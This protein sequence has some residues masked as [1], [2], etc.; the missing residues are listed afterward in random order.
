MDDSMED[1]RAAFAA[2]PQV[3]PADAEPRVREI[4]DDI[5]TVLRVPFVN[6]L[7]RVMANDAEYL[8]RSWRYLR[9]IANSRSFEA[10][11]SKLRMTT[12]SR[13]HIRA[14][15]SDWS[16]LGDLDRA[17]AFT[18]SIDYVLPKLM[19]IAMALDGVPAAE[20]WDGGGEIPAGVAQGAEKVPMVPPKEEVQNLSRV[21]DDI[22]GHHGHP[23]VATYYRA[24]GQ[25]PDL[26]NRIWTDLR[27]HIG[28]EAYLDARSDLIEKAQAL[29]RTL[30]QGD[31]DTPHDLALAMPFFYHRLIPE[32]MLDTATIRCVLAEGSCNPRN[33]FTVAS[34]V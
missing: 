26:L 5:Q 20:E 31:L 16:S 13:L 21:F 28:S 3:M 2:L 15:R 22:R 12:R 27:D 17:G 25:W 10:A 33:A 4:Y 32:L 18:E 34:T 29:A 19:L 9:P 1:A 30:P 24:L 11:T 14:A 6:T 7:F 8:D 23:Q